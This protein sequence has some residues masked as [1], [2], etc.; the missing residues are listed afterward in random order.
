MTRFQSK[1]RNQYV[2]AT[3]VFA[4]SAVLGASGLAGAQPVI[5]DPITIG[6]VTWDMDATGFV[7]D[8][9]Y[10][11]LR[12]DF[13][14]DATDLYFVNIVAWRVGGPPPVWLVENLPLPSAADIGSAS[15]ETCQT[16]DL[17]L[18]GVVR[19]VNVQGDQIEYTV[20]YDPQPLSA[21]PPFSPD[22]LTTIGPQTYS[23]GGDLYDPIP[24][25]PGL[26]PP[27]GPDKPP[28]DG[29]TSLKADL[30][31]GMPNGEQGTNQ[32]GPSG[33]TN[34]MHW[35]EATYPTQVNLLGQ[36][37]NDTL[38]KLK[39]YTNLGPNG[40][41][42][43]A[44]IEGKLR[45]ALDPLK[46]FDPDLNVKY[47]A[48]ATLTDLGA[49]VTVEGKTARRH[50]P[51]GP[52]SF[53]WL[54]SELQRGE[55]VELS[56]DWL[57]N[58]G[59]V[60]HGG[61]VVSVSGAMRFGNKMYIWTNDD[62]QGPKVADPDNPGGPPIPPQNGGLR[63]NMAHQVTIENGGYMRLSGFK[64]NNRVKATY[65]ESVEE[66]QIPTVSEWGLI[67]MTLFGLTMGT[68][69]FAGRRRVAGEGRSV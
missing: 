63:T 61:H 66:K 23:L 13:D 9:E 3:F 4:I 33:I 17:S 55:D 31:F 59:T 22:F 5:Q 39:N 38:L 51:S 47:E 7:P 42:Q 30:R 68:I 36:T 49:S 37:W 32:C 69:V 8:S 40:I 18:L 10:G 29:N 2:P 64:M 62:R 21:A 60:K 56:I 26:D 43:K 1:E 45:F 41:G 12:F 28:W 15:S 65:S 25:T 48:D 34:S 16:V 11:H 52:P 54:L 35:L 14:A 57:N 46:F 20:T 24:V 50:G 58:A 6:Q 27:K 53:D 19:G 67:V 44:A